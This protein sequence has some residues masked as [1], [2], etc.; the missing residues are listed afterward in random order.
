MRAVLDPNVL[1]SALLS[2]AGTPAALLLRWLAGEFELV[3]S[4]LLLAELGRALGYAKIRSRVSEAEAKELLDL[5][6]RSAVMAA[7]PGSARRRSADVDD[8]YLLALAE[9]SAALLVTGD[10]HLLAVKDA[11]V[12]SPRG[13]L[14]RL[15]GE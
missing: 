2:P 1:I 14:D 12:E 15:R 11:A 5:L 4:Q 3:V 9:S 6:R 10:Q 13:L 7:D 8:D